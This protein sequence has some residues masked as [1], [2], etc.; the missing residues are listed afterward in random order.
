[1]VTIRGAVIAGATILILG[2]CGGSI[3]QSV[4]GAGSRPNTAPLHGAVAVPLP[5]P[6][7]GY[8]TYGVP[9]CTT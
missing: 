2:L 4:S 8:K 1:M 3:G 9:S 7:R 5:A 6:C